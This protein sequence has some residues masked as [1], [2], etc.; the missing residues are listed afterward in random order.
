MNENDI[1]KLSNKSVEETLLFYETTMS[2]YSQEKVSELLDIYGENV[3]S[4]KKEKFKLKIFFDSFLNLFN[5]LLLFVVIVSFFTDVAFTNDKNWATIIILLSIILSSG[6]IQ[7]VQE[8]RSHISLRDLKNIVKNTTAVIREGKVIEIDLKEVIVGDIIKLSAGDIIPAD[9]RI[10]Q[11]KDLFISQSTFTGESEPLEKKAISFESNNILDLENIC[12]LGTDVISGTG[13]GIVFATGDNTYLSKMTIHIEDEVIETSFDKG[14]KKVSSL[15]I[16]ATLVLTPIV[17]LINYFFKGSPLTA[18]LFAITVAVGT[19]PELL[20]MVIN[21]NLAKGL[22]NMSKRKVIVKNLHSIQNL[23][24]IDTLCTDKTGTITEDKIILDE[25]LN[26]FGKEDMTVLKYSYLNSSFQTG[27]KSLLDIAIINRAKE[28]DLEKHLEEYK[29]VDEIPFDF[30][31]RRMSVVLETESKEK[32]LITKGATEELLSISKYVLI[33]GKKIK[34]NESLENDIKEVSINLNKRGLRVITVAIKEKDI[35]GVDSFSIKDEDDLIIVGFVS[36]L[37]PPKES[38]KEAITLLKQ[39]GVNTKVITGDNEYVAK[40]VCEQ[41]GIETTYSLTGDDIKN[42]SDEELE[43]EVEKTTLFSKISPIEKSRIIKALQNN[44]HVVG[45]MGDGINDALALKISDVGISVDTGVEIAKETANIVL[46]EKNLLVLEEG[47]VEGRKVFANIM[48]YLNMSISSNIGNMLSFIVAS[49]FIPFL[50]IL[51][52][53]ILFQNLLYDISQLGVSLDRVDQEYIKEP[54]RWNVNGMLRF[55]LW[56]APVS[57]IFDFLIF[58]ILWVYIGANTIANQ[59]IFQSGWFMMGVVSQTIIIFVIRTKKVPF[60]KSKSSKVLIFLSFLISMLGLL[61]PYL[62]VG[63]L[64]G[65]VP[66][67]IV[68]ISALFLV[69][70]MYITFTEFIKILYIKKYG[71]WY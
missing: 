35:G 15:L 37:D 56:F 59:A 24:A 1:I 34:I 14:I 5:G 18:F 38:A 46:L 51:P 7:F 13:I 11:S 8:L 28:N 26:I 49:I 67:P 23:G 33:N 39:H 69:M 42:M 48:K 47:I 10:I 55:A 68:Y 40:N 36:F 22:I 2:G 31:R 29:K 16:K 27:L 65:L 41:V 58:T 70:I 43:K 9:L 20:P 12:F 60:L 53:Q 54:K 44:D 66:L 61:L 3:I 32:L 50:P 25:Y 45:Y 19:T 62:N 71:E 52:I 6:L 30:E 21:S 64:I 4:T 63:K 57:S 17:F